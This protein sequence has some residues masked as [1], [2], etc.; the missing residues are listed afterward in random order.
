MELWLDLGG[1][2]EGTELPGLLIVLSG[3]EVTRELSWLLGVHA[4]PGDLSVLLS[5]RDRLDIQGVGLLH[6]GTTGDS[7]L[8][9]WGKNKV[10][11]RRDMYLCCI[12]W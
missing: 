8:A 9:W 12:F 10:I 4:A 6:C 3:E 7:P 11:V 2:E 1:G 5:R